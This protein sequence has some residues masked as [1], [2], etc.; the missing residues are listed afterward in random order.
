MS[1]EKTKQ[2]ARSVWR[3]VA[4]GCAFTLVVVLLLLWLAGTFHRK[5]G[6]E[7]NGAAT[8]VASTRPVG[9][10]RL[11]AARN[12][13]VPRTE[14]AVGTIEAEHK[15]DVA[16]KLLAKVIEVNVKAGQHVSEGEVLVRLDQADLAARLDQAEAAAAAAQAQ[17]EQARIEYD[18]IKDLFEQGAAAKIEWDRVQTA[19]ATAEADAQ[20]ATEAVT[21]ARTV[22]GY[23]TI[24]SPIDGVVIDKRVEAGDTV[25]PGQVLVSMYDPSRMQLVARVRESLTHRLAVD[26]MIGVRIESL[27]KTCQGRVSE[28]VPEAESKSRTFSVKVTGPCPDGIYSGM[29]GR[30]LIPL[31]EEDVLVIPADAVQRVGQLEMVDVAEGGSLHRRA[32]KLGRAFGEDVQVLAGLHEGEQVAVSSVDAS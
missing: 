15:A 7:G 26:Q 25:S 24:A 4:I 11:V 18:R 22:L 27:N 1:R 5:I 16:S 21:E 17:R 19:F 29:F 28:I 3:L 12:I 10:A 31:D 14:S 23:A 30:L 20:R 9:D 8:T 32:V 2:P 13:S 6:P